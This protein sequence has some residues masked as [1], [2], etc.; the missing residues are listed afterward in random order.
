MPGDRAGLRQRQADVDQRG[1]AQSGNSGQRDPGG[2]LGVTVRLSAQPATEE[3][4]L[5]KTPTFW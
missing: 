3:T 5:E 1:S 2:V 4:D